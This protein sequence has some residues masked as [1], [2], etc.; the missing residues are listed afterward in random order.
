MAKLRIGL[1]GPWGGNL[2]D[3]ATARAMIEQIQARFPDA[4]L[5][6]LTLYP[7]GAERITGIPCL[8][9]QRP[10][11]ESEAVVN[12]WHFRLSARMTSHSNRLIR[13][14]GRWVRR[15]PMELSLI[16]YSNEI[17]K[18]ID[19]LIITGGGQLEDEWGGAFSHPY[20]L[21]KFTALARWHK[22][23]VYMPSVGAGPIES[24]LSKI[25]IKRVLANASYRSYR[26]LA[27]K[28][29]IDSIGFRRSDPVYPDLAWSLQLDQMT[30]KDNHVQTLPKVGIGPMTWY[31][32]R[33]WPKKDQAIYQGYIDRLTGFVLRLLENGNQVSFIP[34]ESE[35][36]QMAIDDVLSALARNGIAAQDP[37][38][39][40]ATIT[41]VEEY[42][43]EMSTLDF[44]V[45][46]RFHTIVFALALQKPAIALAYHQ[47]MTV[48][49]DE[50][51]LSRYCLP[52]ASFDVETTWALFNEMKDHAAEVRT[53]ILKVLPLYRAALDRQ[54]REILDAIQVR[55][56]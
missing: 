49:M 54:Y 42:I 38:L 5:I 14:L 40:R 19:V 8:P 20:S 10:D 46:S 51:S 44:F 16:S 36:D 11:N 45:G 18:K 55:G 21:L 25:F 39:T 3:A 27:S 48:L 56:Q 37:R 47:K 50:F 22:I 12:S 15:L 6:G 30:R 1:M 24:G 52:I 35:H 53:S 23:V 7:S 41:N 33:I 17:V 26:D 43:A 13:E 9:I 28:Q 32:P 31:D 2:G 29:L 4:E 34:G